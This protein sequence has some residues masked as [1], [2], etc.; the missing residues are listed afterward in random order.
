[1]NKA[2][3]IIIAA[4]LIAACSGAQPGSTPELREITGDTIGMWVTT[5]TGISSIFVVSGQYYLLGEQGSHYEIVLANRTDARLEVV[6]S[7]DGRD[8]ITGQVANF[9]TNRGYVLMPGE[10][11]NIEGF[12][13]SLDEVAAF[14]FS[15]L[16]ESYAAKLGDPANVGV[17]GAAVFEE[18]PAEPSKA[19]AGDTKSAPIPEVPTMSGPVDH[20]APKE[21]GV[22]TKYGENLSSVA[23]VVPFRRRVEG[24]PNEL[25]V[26]YYDEREGLERIGVVFSETT[27]KRIVSKEPNPFPGVTDDEEGFAPPPP[28]R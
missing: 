8:V 27:P 23:E 16:D 14:E 6:V 1:M 28:T 18:E 26:L 2:V 21:Q 15:A 22:G 19:I 3:F 20:A 25:I 4:L 7:V 24:E 12:R 17:I 10:E 9:L 5:D 11:I 13:R